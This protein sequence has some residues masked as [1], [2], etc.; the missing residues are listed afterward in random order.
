MFIASAAVIVAGV[1]IS[2]AAHLRWIAFAILIS[3]PRVLWAAGSI[4]VAWTERVKRP[5]VT[6][7]FAALFIRVADWLTEL[8]VEELVVLRAALLWWVARRTVRIVSPSLAGL[9]WIAKNTVIIHAWATHLRWIAFAESLVGKECI[10]RAASLSAVALAKLGVVYPGVSF[11]ETACLGRIAFTTPV[12]GEWIVWAACC[13]WIALAVRIGLPCFEMWSIRAALIN[14]WNAFAIF[15]ICIS[16]PRAARSIEDA[17]MLFAF[18]IFRP[19]VAFLSTAFEV[20]VTAFI[21]LIWA[22]VLSKWVRYAYAVQVSREEIFVTPK[23]AAFRERI[24]VAVG[25]GLVWFSWAAVY[26]RVAAALHEDFTPGKGV[27]GVWFILETAN[28][29]FEKSVAHHAADVH[30]CALRFELDWNRVNLFFW[31][32]ALCQRNVL[33]DSGSWVLLE[34][35]NHSLLSD[36]AWRL[37]LQ[38]SDLHSSKSRRNQTFFHVDL[39]LLKKDIFGRF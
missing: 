32:L 13:A 8:W 34:D 37:K 26:R 28:V 22:A 9:A 5:E 36:F 4:G 7:F 24:A 21:D 6:I 12:S 3:R 33:L 39:V 10:I 17:F 35:W 15:V 11:R 14:S 27:N 2:L 25:V 18:W 20:R 31:C 16:L 38:S 29:L 23:V 1:N 19:F 30:F